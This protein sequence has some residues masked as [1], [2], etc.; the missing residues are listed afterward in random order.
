[1]EGR[2]RQRERETER[3]R[4]REREREA[5]RWGL[6]PE[7]SSA[8]FSLMRKI[9][10]RASRAGRMTKQVRVR[11]VDDNDEECIVLHV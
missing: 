7:T 4:E 10:S 1:M 9:Y 8:W 6:L 5:V 2:E 3:E 11:D